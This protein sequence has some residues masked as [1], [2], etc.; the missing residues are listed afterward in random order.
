MSALINSWA[1]LN[2]ESVYGVT[3]VGVTAE[4][5]VGVVPVGSVET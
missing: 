1:N 3:S 4:K 5:A 2:I